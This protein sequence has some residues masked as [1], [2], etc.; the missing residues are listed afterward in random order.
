[1]KWTVYRP[2]GHLS[3]EGK[4]KDGEKKVAR[5]GYLGDGNSG[6]MFSRREGMAR[7]LV[8]QAEAVEAGVEEEGGLGLVWVGKIIVLSDV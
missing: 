7:W 6:G 2:G 4:V 5:A 8:A 3:V 1:M